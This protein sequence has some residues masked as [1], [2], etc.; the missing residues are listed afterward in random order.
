MPILL[1][2]RLALVEV[3]RL[4]S[5]TSDPEQGLRNFLALQTSLLQGTEGEFGSR[6]RPRQERAREA[7]RCRAELSGREVTGREWRVGRCD[8]WELTFITILDYTD[9]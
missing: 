3:A 1:A 5:E 6:A 8:G 4:G 2:I 9:T 7:W